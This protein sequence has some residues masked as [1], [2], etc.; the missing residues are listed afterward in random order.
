MSSSQGSKV[1]GIGIYDKDCLNLL[2]LLCAFL[3]V[4]TIIARILKCQCCLRTSYICRILYSFI[5]TGL[6]LIF[7]HNPLV[8]YDHPHLSTDILPHSFFIQIFAL[9]IITIHVDVEYLSFLGPFQENFKVEY[10]Y[11]NYQT[12][13]KQRWQLLPAPSS[14]LQGVWTHT[15]SER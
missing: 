15:G 8:I 14:M 1:K 7:L 6:G 2:L 5:H 10:C 12:W 4:A 9:N 3:S 13:D 11:I